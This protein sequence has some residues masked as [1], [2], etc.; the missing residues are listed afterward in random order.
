MLPIRAHQQ[1][2]G[3]PREEAVDG[4]EESQH[5]RQNDFPSVACHSFHHSLGHLLCRHSQYITKARRGL[6]ASRPRHSAGFGN[7]KR[8]GSVS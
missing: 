6:P 4:V 2:P 1:P 7:A 3:E 8:C 5:E